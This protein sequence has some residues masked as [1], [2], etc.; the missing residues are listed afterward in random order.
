MNALYIVDAWLYSCNG[1]LAVNNHYVSW[2]RANAIESALDS[3]RNHPHSFRLAFSC[4]FSL[5]LLASARWSR[6][7][8]PYSGASRIVNHGGIVAILHILAT[9]NTA[10]SGAFDPVRMTRVTAILLTLETPD[11]R[12]MSRRGCKRKDAD[13]YAIWRTTVQMRVH[14]CCRATESRS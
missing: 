13:C 4:V 3:L 2:A 11:K 8:M 5:R 9:F 1:C 14:A 10:T 7:L 6:Y 12:Q